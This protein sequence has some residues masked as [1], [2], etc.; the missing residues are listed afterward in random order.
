[1]AVVTPGYTTAPALAEAWG[2]NWSN[3]NAARNHAVLAMAH[4]GI[5]SV[6]YVAASGRVINVPTDVAV[7]RAILTETTQRINSQTVSNC[8]RLGF[9]FVQVSSCCD[10]R[11]SHAFWQGKVYQLVGQGKYP[12]YYTA[13]KVGDMVDGIGG[14]NC[15]HRV[16]S[17]I[18]GQPLRPSTQDPL[19]GTGYTQQQARELTSRQRALENEIRKL[20]R[21][22]AVGREL[23]LDTSRA[24]GLQKR[25]TQ[26]LK[27]LTSDHPA[28][29][30]YEPQRLGINS[31][32]LKRIGA[33]VTDSPLGAVNRG[34]LD[35]LAGFSTGDA[36]SKAKALINA[37]RQNEKYV[38]PLL[39]KMEGDGTRLTGLENRI[40][41]QDSLVRKLLT[42]AKV[43]E[44]IPVTE[45]DV[46]RYT[47]VIGT[48]D[49]ASQFHIISNELN[50]NGLRATGTRNTLGDADAAYRGIN[51]N[52]AMPD[53]SELEIQFHTPES[54]NIKE[55]LNH[56][57]YEESRL[58]STS[59]QRRKELAEQMAKN[60]K[61]I[62]MP[63]GI[64]S[65]I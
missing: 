2:N 19:E 52:W 6:R 38:T 1:M 17:Y 44:A 8:Q 18:D 10:A 39:Q 31:R 54:I 5:T 56:R 63:P 15:H 33:P 47:Y 40:K 45:R 37:A 27:A 60:S 43:K 57:L 7:R 55:S 49:I 14:Y 3:Y 61:T 12:N 41:G 26:Q 23:G 58:S 21:E 9:H 65:V 4:D 46:L 42:D 25:F 62:P 51:T 29:L 13:C 48:D 24:N 35:R 59:S 30:R 50:N 64:R 34:R 20:K 11:E 53:G 32:S 16:S 22:Q 36:T 28:I